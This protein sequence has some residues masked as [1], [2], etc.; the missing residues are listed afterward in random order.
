MENPE[1]EIQDALFDRI[2][3]N[4]TQLNGN[5]AK[6]NGLFS[7]IEKENE[8]TVLVSKLWDFYTKTAEFHL[9]KTGSLEG[10]IRE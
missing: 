3:K 2:I 8:N 10:P 6:I 1:E 9:E 5:V 4:L 7:E